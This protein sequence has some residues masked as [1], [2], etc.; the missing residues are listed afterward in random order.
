MWFNNC[1]KKYFFLEEQPKQSQPDLPL[2][3]PDELKEK[4]SERHVSFDNN[5]SSDL[6]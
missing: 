4:S 5:K 2:C 6:A 3:K 1:I